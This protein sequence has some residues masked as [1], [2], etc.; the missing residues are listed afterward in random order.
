MGGDVIDPTHKEWKAAR[1]ALARTL[2]H[3]AV[4]ASSRRVDE[5]TKDVLGPC[6]PEPAPPHHYIAGRVVV[7]PSMSMAKGTVWL[8]RVGDITPD[9]AEAMADALCAHAHHA[10]KQEAT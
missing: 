5:I 6:P 1:T 7:A 9:E 10:R 8:V 2:F 4:V 3:N